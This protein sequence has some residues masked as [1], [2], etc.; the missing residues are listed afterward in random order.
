MSGSRDRRE[1]REGIWG[2]EERE[3]KQGCRK[4]LD[5]GG[6]G[7][8]GGASGGVKLELKVGSFKQN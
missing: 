2:G 3:I 8:V 7:A 1:K 5:V 6:D 4:L